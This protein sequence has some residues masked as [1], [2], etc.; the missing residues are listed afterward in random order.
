MAAAVE[1]DNPAAERLY[2]RLGYEFVGSDTESWPTVGAAGEEELYTTDV[3][4]MAKALD[5]RG[6]TARAGRA[7]R[8][9]R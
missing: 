9:P 3:V 1:I 8:A 7:G 2:R 4:V 5:G 6:W